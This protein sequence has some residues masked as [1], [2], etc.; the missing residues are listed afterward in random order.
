MIVRL[1]VAVLL[2]RLI[3][4]GLYPLTDP[5]EGRYAEIGRL[6][7]QLQDWVTPRLS[8]A[9]PFWGKP[10]FTFWATAVSI[11][12]FGE[13]E[14][15]ARLPHFLMGLLVIWALWGLMIR[16]VNARAALL[17]TALITAAVV[18]YVSAGAIMTDMGLTL[19]FVLA[20]RGFWLAMDET[21]PNRTREGYYFFLGLA[22]GLLSKGPLVLVVSLTPIGLWV[23]Y[24][25]NVLL[26][27]KVLPWVKGSALLLLIVVPWYILAEIRTPGFL[28]Y[29]IIGEHFQ[30]YLIPGWEG[31]LYATGR[32]RPYGTIWL[33]GLI[34]A[35]PWTVILPLLAWRGRS[36][37]PEVSHSERQGWMPYLFLWALVLLVFFTFSSNVLIAYVLPVLAPLAALGGTW[38]ARSP[39]VRRVD[40]AVAT[41]LVLTA[42]CSAGFIAYSNTENG[43]TLSARAATQACLAHVPDVQKIILL[44]VTADS[45]A[46]Y[47]RSRTIELEDDAKV[48]QALEDHQSL[49]VILSPSSLR[50]LPEQTRSKL[51]DLGMH[52]K[53]V[54]LA[55]K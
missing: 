51:T 48:S 12:V 30:R 28:E 36:D 47:S 1:I 33:F 14:F 55:I 3:T 46:F 49:C 22:I 13:N 29:F 5:T 40:R 23:L 37:R 26:M 42:L 17:A 34:G 11:Y 21:Q 6:M 9:V 39:N 27:F 2:F 35:L 4:L 25:R 10:P 19:G 32:E 41:G 8:E 15:A 18:F 53:F 44:R 38:L 50:T 7:V 24:S 31:D 52:G 43:E 45:A 16:A 54:V 20:M